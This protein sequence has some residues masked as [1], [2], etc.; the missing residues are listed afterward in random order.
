M[1]PLP[2]DRVVVRYRLGVGG[3]D[4]WRA[5]SGPNPAFERAPTLSDLTGILASATPDGLVIERDGVPEYVPAAAVTSI[6]QLS[7]RVV[8]NSEIRAVERILTDAVAAAERAE[9]DGW[10]VSADPS[11]AAVRANAA[12]PLEFGAN[13]AGLDRVRDW[14]A[15]RGIAARAV[16]PERLLRTAEASASAGAA[17]EVLVAPDGTPV[18]VPG[19]D[20]GERLRRRADG[21]ALHHTFRLIDL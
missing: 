18:E 3:P 11:S 6:R 1:E 14:Y 19:V 12:V 17:Y 16:V 15:S 7:A 20:R 13:A 2:G 9:V 8:R 5:A 4:D 10:T 21:Y